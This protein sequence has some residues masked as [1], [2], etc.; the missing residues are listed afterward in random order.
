MKDI[1]SAHL[2]IEEVTAVRMGDFPFREA[3]GTKHIM[4]ELEIDPERGVIYFHA[5]N[6]RTL[7]RICQL[8]T[9]IPLRALDISH[10]W[11]C[12]W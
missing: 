3:G 11:G 7:L 8:P 1:D 12:D 5:A 10:G 2:N 6:G 4:G 9:P